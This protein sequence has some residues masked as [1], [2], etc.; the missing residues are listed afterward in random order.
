MGKGGVARFSRRNV[1]NLFR[2]SR[3]TKII[4]LVI[5]YSTEIALS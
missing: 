3:A 1:I 4:S 5:L 2:F